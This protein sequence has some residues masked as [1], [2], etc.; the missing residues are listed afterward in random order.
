MNKTTFKQIGTIYYI[1]SQLITIIT[2]DKL[3]FTIDRLSQK[4]FSKYKLKS[5]DVVYLICD[6]ENHKVLTLMDAKTQSDP[7]D[8]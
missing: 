3:V 1:S 4:E 7:G 2:N 6:K 5:G 8:L